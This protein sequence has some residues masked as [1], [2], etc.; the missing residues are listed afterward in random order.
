MLRELHISGLGVID[1]LDLPLH[2]G[3]NVLTGETGAGKTMI[4]VGLALALGARASVSA[5]REGARAARVQA[6]F[7]VAEP[8][9]GA[10]EALEAW[11]DD[12]EVLLARSV[13]AEGK[14]SARI[15]GQLATASA[16]ASIGGAL[17]EVH[18]QFQ[19]QRLLL[20]VVQT[21]FLDRFAGD[22][23]LVAV[24]AYRETF[25]AFR[26]AEAEL[27]RLR[28]A[29]RDR[30]RELD[31]LAY[32][33][34]EIG[35]VGP[36]PGE[37]ERLIAE[38][39]RLGHV[40]RLQEAATAA[41]SALDDDERGASLGLGAAANALDEAAELD[42]GRR[43]ARRAGVG[44]RARGRRTGA[45]RADLPRV[46]RR[47]SSR[48]QLA[49]ERLA[50][51]KALQ[52]KYGERDVDVIEFMREAARRLAEL[53]GADDRIAEL[54]ADVGTLAERLA[55]RGTVVSGGRSEAAGRLAAAIGGELE[56]LGMP[57]AVVEVALE[58]LDGAGRQRAGACGAAI[59]G[60]TRDDPDAAREDGLGRR[61]V[62]HDAG[63]PERAR[64]PRR[65]ADARVR[66]GRCRHRRPGWPR[67]R[68]GDSRPSPPAA[69]C[70]SSHTCHRSRA[71]PIGTC[72]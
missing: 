6:L 36:E 11:T 29:G 70:W 60:R 34:R 3:L 30:E 46:A 63:V 72:G 39:G 64:R 51:L 27:D 42:A 53:E 65:R 7:D 56:Q 31:L 12:D 57:G 8:P 58:P 25:E 22:E 69:R 55:T 43:R 23:H 20:P 45:R 71:S 52:R 2:P 15:G 26:V 10:R 35:D 24:A 4:T 49:R 13:P 62:A 16:L 32:Q 54:E 14:G 67:G 21:G 59:R 37:S 18:G 33:V 28:E 1:D 19:A 68:A 38:A 44:R 40:E 66:R 9:P 47:R 5:V 17:V 41:G 48:L 50:A 61:A